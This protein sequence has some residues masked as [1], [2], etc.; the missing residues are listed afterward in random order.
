MLIDAE[1]VCSLDVYE[2]TLLAIDELRFIFSAFQIGE[3]TNDAPGHR[4]TQSLDE[5]ER[6]LVSLP[7]ETFRALDQFARLIDNNRLEIGLAVSVHPR[8]ASPFCV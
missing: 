6:V 3:P 7:L 1:P 4:V 8:Y 5:R 2:R